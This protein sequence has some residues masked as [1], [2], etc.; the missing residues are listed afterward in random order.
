MNAILCLKF[1]ALAHAGL[2]AAGAVMPR[3]TGLWS[4]IAKLPPFPRTLF[5]VYYAFIGLC[6]A[7][8]GAGSW[9]LAQELASGTPLA[10]GVCAFLAAF[11]TLRLVAAFLLDVRPF[12]TGAGWKAGY[13]ATSV[14]FGALPLIYGWIALR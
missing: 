9:L 10:R 2:I 8:F 13:A 4:A 14:V 5:K 7:S 12:L 11:W 1:A 6:L 3:A